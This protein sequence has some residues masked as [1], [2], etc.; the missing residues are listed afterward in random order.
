MIRS[1]DLFCRVVDNLGDAGVCLR[2]A[3]QLVVEHGLRVWLWIDDRATLD[4][5]VPNGSDDAALLASGRLAVAAWSETGGACTAPA[6]VTTGSGIAHAAA[7]TASWAAAARPGA[8]LVIEAFGCDLPVAYAEALARRRPPALWYNLEYL[9]AEDWVTSCHALPS[10]HPTLTVS[11]HFFFPGFGPGTGGL[12][13]EAALIE[14][15]RRFQAAHAADAGADLDVGLFCYPEA[16]LAAL[17]DAFEQ[18]PVGVRCRVFQGEAQAIVRAWAERH[19]AR[20]TELVWL[21]WLSQD[22]FDRELWSC[23]FNVVRGEDSFVRAQWAGRPFLWDIYPQSDG[24][25][26]IKMAAFLKRYREGLAAEPAQALGSLWQ[27]WVRRDPGAL[28]TA[29]AGLVPELVALR[30][31]AERWCDAQAARPD[32]VTAL[33]EHARSR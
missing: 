3:R 12:L 15:R 10:P 22:A 33:L 18:G 2:L 25:H 28:A 29:W 31:H 30:A 5:L 24:A 11:R 16:E 19:P 14:R 9:S 4:R 32:L 23:D 20:R 27:P 17:L 26:L 7:T 6:A 1:V 13:R 21:P 8:D